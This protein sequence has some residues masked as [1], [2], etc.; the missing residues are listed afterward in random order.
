MR[1]SMKPRAAL[2]LFVSLTALLSL[3]ALAPGP[4]HAQTTNP[5][6]ALEAPAATSGGWS[7]YF[8]NLYPDDAAPTATV[9]L[10]DR[11]LGFLLDAAFSTIITMVGGG[12]LIMAG[13]FFDWLAT[14]SL[15]GTMYQSG[16]GSIVYEGWTIFRDLANILFIFILIYIGIATILRLASVQTYK[17]LA[18]VIVIALLINFSLVIT[19]VVIDASN[20]LALTFYDAF[21]PRNSVIGVLTSPFAGLGAT[22]SLAAPFVESS[23]LLRFFSS[24]L[25]D[26]WL[27]TRTPGSGV[28]ASGVFQVAVYNI[29]ELVVLLIAT[30]VLFAAGLLFAIRTVILMMLM[31]LSPIAFAM[32]ILPGTEGYARK[33]WSTLLN[34]AFFAPIFLALYYVTA[35]IFGRLF[36]SINITN[37]ATDFYGS[38]GTIIINFAV[39]AIFLIS[40]L[41]ISK[42]LGA[43]GAGTLMSKGKKWGKRGAGFAARH[44]VGRGAYAIQQQIAQS[45]FAQKSPRTA[46][47]LYG[48]AG[49]TAKYGFGGQKGGYEE[50]LKNAEKRQVAMIKAAA[51]D[52][53]GASIGGVTELRDEYGRVVRKGKTDEAVRISRAQAQ[54]MEKLNKPSFLGVRFKRRGGGSLTQEELGKMNTLRN[55][56]E[57]LEKTKSDG[58]KF[59]ADEK[60]R[61][62]VLHNTSGELNQLISRHERLRQRTVANRETISEFVKTQGKKDVKQ[63]ILDEAKDA[64]EEVEPGSPAPASAPPSAPA[65][66]TP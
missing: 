22:K 5:A 53:S 44:T 21:P 39:V 40:T 41:I 58:K 18:R 8:G 54:M 10:V 4:I 15:L 2:F 48:A 34:Q 24:P 16:Q 55:E 52:R 26:G 64:G 23:G 65:G 30:F 28:I 49:A 60:N 20:I 6:P 33:W 38:I 46:A 66:G 25:F 42:Q 51:T 50:A 1:I 12:L 36:Q 17:L 47:I 32:Y 7:A 63:Q 43:Y 13:F 62:A 35:R 19:R 11:L 45:G 37:T 3:V 31:I 9:G 56:R 59:T 29:S 61:F 27:T 57:M 14:F